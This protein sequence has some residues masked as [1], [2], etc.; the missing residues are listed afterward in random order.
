VRGEEGERPVPG[1]R[2]GLGVVARRR[3]VVE[4]VVHVRVEVDAELLAVL[5]QRR[6]VGRPARVDALVEARVV[7][8][9]RRLDRGT[10]AASGW[11]P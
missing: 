3:V 5:D 2:R 4:A 9:E 8:L 11:R 6:L 1:E 7:D 10:S